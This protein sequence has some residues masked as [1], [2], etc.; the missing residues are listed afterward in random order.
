M[1]DHQMERYE[2]ELR[3]AKPAPPPES[4]M[5]RLRA[6]KLDPEPARPHQS[7]AAPA[8]AKASWL[9]WLAP[10]MAAAVVVATV[11]RVATRPSSQHPVASN[12]PPISALAYGLNADGVRVDQELVSSYD[13]VAE[14][15]GGEPVRFRCRKWKD[16]WVVT[17]TNRGVEIEEDSPR[18]EVMPVRLETY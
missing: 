4:F 13:V 8:R 3:R 11:A 7:T 1:N 16:K 15:P 10:A 14:L 2:A 9:R 5:E 6:S 17:D 12:D 18:I